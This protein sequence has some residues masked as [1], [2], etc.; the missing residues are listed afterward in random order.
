MCGW[1]EKVAMREE[2]E[3]ERERVKVTLSISSAPALRFLWETDVHN[4]IQCLIP[5][6]SLSLV[7]A[8]PTVYRHTHTHVHT[9]THWAYLPAS[10]GLFTVNFPLS[11]GCVSCF[12]V[13]T[14]YNLVLLPLLSFCTSVFSHSIFISFSWRCWAL[15]CIVLVCRVMNSGDLACLCQAK[16]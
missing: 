5:L 4:L 16:L 8:Q 2:G 13:N 14:W 1:R 6:H 15:E 9:Q 3:R 7:P 10:W 11:P 12:W